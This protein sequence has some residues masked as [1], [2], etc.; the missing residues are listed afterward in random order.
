VKRLAGCDSSCF[1]HRRYYNLDICVILSHL[2]GEAQQVVAL[3]PRP[4]PKT[5]VFVYLGQRLT[6]IAYLDEF[7][8]I[9]PYIGRTDPKHNDSPV[10]GLAGF[11]ITASEVRN[12]GTWF[13]KRKCELL[14]FEI[15]RSGSHPALWEKKGA[16]LYTVANVTKYAELRQFTNRLLNK[17]ESLGGFV[18][19]VG[20]KKSAKIDLHNPNRLYAR[21]LLEA[22]KRI[23]S[24][25]DLDCVP[26]SNFILALDEHD[27]RSALITEAARSMYSAV[28]PRRRLIEPPFHLESHRYQTVQAA[29]WIAGLV[30]RFGAFWAD[31]E[32]YP[33]NAIFMKY[34]EQRLHRVARRSGIRN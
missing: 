8:H 17:I 12:F 19:Y 29:D 26:P 21:V 27:Q 14:D 4:T 5:W 30:G 16:S 31:P 7:G 2:K 22:I 15:K 11:V 1:I 10:F 6:Y 20:I 3:F 18:F 23:D 28:Q 24:F 33:E 25:C 13:F 9:G 34:F 32:A